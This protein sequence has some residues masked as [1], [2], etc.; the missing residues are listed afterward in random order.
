MKLRNFILVITLIKFSCGDLIIAQTKDSLAA[1]NY[2]KHIVYTLANDSFMGREVSTA[3]EL[4][5]AN[6]VANEFKK[7]KKFKPQWQSF[8]YQKYD[9]SVAKSS[10]NIYCFINNKADSTVVIGAHYEH[11][12]LGGKL[13]LGYN[14]KNQIHNGADDNASGVALLLSLAKNYSNWG[15]KKVN[16]LFVAYSAH[17]I[18]LFGSLAFY[19]FA[20][21]KFPPIKGCI[22]FDMV[23]R[24]DVYNESNLTFLGIHQFDKVFR[25][26]LKEYKSPNSKVKLY[27]D[28]SDDILLTDCKIFYKNNIKS[29][30]ITSGTHNDYHKPDDDAEYI[31]YEGIY[32][33]QKVVEELL[34]KSNYFSK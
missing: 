33:I 4:K 17:E 16:Y 12:G 15:N 22:N 3:H 13:S 23:G 34:L 21:T 32:L 2:Y 19:D 5:A 7:I 10:N 18:G 6:F 1:I 30:S 31:K 26:K 28:K 29:L 25:G 11:I 27:L 20:K 9:T 24:L 14:K 8:I